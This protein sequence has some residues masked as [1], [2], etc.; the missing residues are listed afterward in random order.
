M[1]ST[2]NLIVTAAALVAAGSLL[3]ALVSLKSASP[4][5]AVVRTSTSTVCGRLGTDKNGHVT[6]AGNPVGPV[7]QIIL[8]T[9]CG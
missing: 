1:D 6:V 4:T 9:S 2:K 3:V 7:H 5:L 8:V